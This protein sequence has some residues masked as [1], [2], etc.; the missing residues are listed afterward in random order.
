MRP[1]VRVPDRHAVREAREM[2]L[3]KAQAKTAQKW[4]R[5]KAKNPNCPKC[6]S[7]EWTIG[8]LV[9]SPSYEKGGLLFGGDVGFPLLVVKCDNCGYVEQWAAD[10]IGIG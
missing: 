9:K 7:N 3:K 6:D 2:S 5:D 10:A 1:G 8:D 4:I